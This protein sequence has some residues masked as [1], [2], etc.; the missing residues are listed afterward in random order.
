MDAST[1]SGSGSGGAAY[2][3]AAASYPSFTRAVRS[4]SSSSS[5]AGG[6]GGAAKPAAA[7]I[8]CGSDRQ[9]LEELL[10]SKLHE[11]LGFLDEGTLS[12]WR[13]QEPHVR[14]LYYAAEG[15]DGELLGFLTVYEVC[16][17]VC[18]GGVWW[19]VPCV[20]VFDGVTSGES[21]C[22]SECSPRKHNHNIN[23]RWSAT[24]WGSTSG[25]T[26]STCSL[27]SA[28]TGARASPS[29]S[30]GACVSLCN[31]VIM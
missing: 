18:D 2:M 19:A 16:A 31:F 14:C 13:G 3:H 29:S 26:S 17:C 28:S 8:T 22:A 30:S 10:K 4:F 5:S 12:M 21:S 27:S 24:R 15:E 20:C 23:N 11:P 9:A 7:R 1:S 6:G 25:R